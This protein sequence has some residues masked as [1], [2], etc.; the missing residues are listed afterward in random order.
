MYCD[1][2]KRLMLPTTPLYNAL[3]SEFWELVPHKQ[4]AAVTD[5]GNSRSSVP[6]EPV[7]PALDT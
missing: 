6:T 4:A 2:S 3:A 1:S 5:L 7:P